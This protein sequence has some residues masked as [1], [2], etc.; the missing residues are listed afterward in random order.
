MYVSA[1]IS[2]VR[3]SED[4]V[5]KEDWADER[6]THFL[7]DRKL[8]VVKSRVVANH[9]TESSADEQVV[10]EGNTVPG[11]DLEDRTPPT[12]CWWRP[13]TNRRWWNGLDD[14]QQAD[15][16]HELQVDIRPGSRSDDQI[17]ECQDVA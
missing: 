17:E 11:S 15:L 13:W 8:S 3:A 7:V 5:W 4:T 1:A 10:G 16:L 6:G 2:W 12:E 9:L 14:G